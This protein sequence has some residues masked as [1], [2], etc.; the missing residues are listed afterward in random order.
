MSGA[1][2]HLDAVQVGA[3][4]GPVLPLVAALAK[5]DR[6]SRGWNALIAALVAA[7]ATVVGLSAGHLLGPQ[8]LA[9]GFAVVYTT[10]VAFHH[11]LWL[12]T[13]LAPWLQT[14]TSVRRR[15]G[16]GGDGTGPA[17]IRYTPRP[18]PSG[19]HNG[20]RP[21]ADLARC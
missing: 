19:R 7:V 18:D 12:P 14:A 10:A 6:L 4:I 13:G 8:N 11:G 20:T 5:Q 2:T 21:P 17:P 3:L 9:V 16:P 1:G 15:T